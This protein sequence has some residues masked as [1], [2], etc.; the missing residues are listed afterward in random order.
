M[1]V[2]LALLAAAPSLVDQNL[3]PEIERILDRQEREGAK[4]NDLSAKVYWEK[5]DPVADIRQ[6]RWGQCEFL[7]RQKENDARFRIEFLKRRVLPKGRPSMKSELWIFDGQYLIE[8]KEVAKTCIR[9]RMTEKG[10]KVKLFDVGEGV[11]PVP[12]GQKKADVLKYY[13]VHST[14]PPEPGDKGVQ[15]VDVLTLIPREGTSKST[16]FSK[17]ELHIDRSLGLPTTII[18]HHKKSKAINKYEFS[19][20]RINQ[21]VDPKRFDFK[22][23]AGW[24]VQT[25]EQGK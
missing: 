13:K 11:F 6:G 23:P 9:R 3:S 24:D 4:V 2:W 5:H 16:E 21:G 25:D 22:P 1:I 7:R 18:V 19:D 17:I 15:A 12:F 10:E 20:V 8:A 14:H